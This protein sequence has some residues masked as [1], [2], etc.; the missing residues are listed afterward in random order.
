MNT[1]QAKKTKGLVE[2]ALFAAIILV[3]AFTPFVGYIP[4][5]PVKA[6]TVHI[7]VIIGSI[8]LGWKRG[9][10]LGFIFGLTSFLGASFISPTIMSF[11]FSPL[12]PG[13][14]IFSLV[15]C[16]VPRILIGI[17][18]YLVYKIVRKIIPK[19]ETPAICLGALAGSLTNTI[20]V[21]GFTYLFFSNEYASA[22]NIAKEAVLGLIIGV[23]GTNGVPEAIVAAIISTAVCKALLALK[24][25]NRI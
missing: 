21:M 13:G 25:H 10:V 17:N 15:I 16:F 12:Y 1:K 22:K 8:V 14:N 5:G 23:V 7:P 11:M 18:A 2:A 24:K 9:A 4:I 19:T 3:L 20:L 6:T